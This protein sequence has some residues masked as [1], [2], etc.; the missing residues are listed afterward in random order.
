MGRLYL[1][2]FEIWEAKGPK[3]LSYAANQLGYFLYNSAQYTEAEPLYKRALA[4]DEASLGKDHPNVATALN[5]LAALYEA[6]NRLSEA[7]PLMKRALAIVLNFTQQTGHQ[8]PHLNVA[9]GNYAGLLQAMGLADGQI[10][11]RLNEILKP[12]GMSLGG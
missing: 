1:R 6:T 10:R 2:S 8:H 3:N 9:I 11:S 5:N 12:F 4:I 7:E